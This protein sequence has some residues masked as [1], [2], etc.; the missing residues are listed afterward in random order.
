[1]GGSGSKKSKVDVDANGKIVRIV[2]LGIGGVNL[3]SI[4][5]DNRS[6]NLPLP[7]CLCKKNSLENMIQRK[8][9]WLLPFRIGLLYFRKADNQRTV[10]ENK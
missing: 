3:K 8:F 5:A 9:F 2:M 10:T 7:L 4:F 6:E 1:M